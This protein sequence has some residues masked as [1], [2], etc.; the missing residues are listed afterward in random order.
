MW[1]DVDVAK[2]LINILNDLNRKRL[3][4]FLIM[5]KSI[6]RICTILQNLFSEALRGGCCSIDISTTLA[7]YLK[8]LFSWTVAALPLLGGS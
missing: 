5:E 8:A 1:D 3:M 7:G 2:W 4:L 6:L